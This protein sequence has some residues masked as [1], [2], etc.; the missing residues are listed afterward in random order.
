MWLVTF[1]DIKKTT[2]GQSCLIQNDEYY[3]L[4]FFDEK[5]PI[6]SKFDIFCS[7]MYFSCHLRKFNL[8]HK[9]YFIITIKVHLQFT[10]KRFNKIIAQYIVIKI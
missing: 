10:S 1:I 9:N 6:N 7:L 4:L 2:P 3:D 8:T 5:L